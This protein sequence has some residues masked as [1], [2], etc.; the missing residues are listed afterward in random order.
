MCTLLG[1]SRRTLQNNIR[2][3]QELDAGYWLND[4]TFR[5][6][7]RKKF[8]PKFYNRHKEKGLPLKVSELNTSTLHS[9]SYLALTQTALWYQRRNNKDKKD[10]LTRETLEAIRASR[11]ETQLELAGRKHYSKG[12][13][14][15]SFIKACNKSQTSIR[16]IARQLVRLKDLDRLSIV[17]PKKEVLTA[18]LN[19][20]V[21][22]VWHEE[23]NNYVVR[24]KKDRFLLFK[25]IPNTIQVCGVSP[26][27]NTIM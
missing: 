2:Q 6:V 16:T 14:S 27:S 10:K 18:T 7:S 17:K 8:I 1:I 25:N 22:K 19:P 9:L 4:Y 13:I 12:Q 15:S 5:L 23:S 3:L 21:A 20:S 24:T 11:N 26:S